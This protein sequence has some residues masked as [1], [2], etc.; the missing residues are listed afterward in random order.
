MPATTRAGGRQTLNRHL[1]WKEAATGHSH[2]LLLAI[3]YEMM[4]MTSSSFEIRASFITRMASGG[5]VDFWRPSDESKIL[6]RRKGFQQIITFGDSR[7][8]LPALRAGRLLQASRAIS[9]GGRYRGIRA[10]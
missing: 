1:Y 4:C 3:A 6:P 8:G 10:G 9:V 5:S 7:G 2:L